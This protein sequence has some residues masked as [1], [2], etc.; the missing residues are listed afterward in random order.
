M[1]LYLGWIQGRGSPEWTRM[2]VKVMLRGMIINMCY[3]DIYLRNTDKFYLMNGW[4]T[5]KTSSVEP[6]SIERSW[7]SIVYFRTYTIN[8]SGVE[9]TCVKITQSSQRT[10][11]FSSYKDNTYTYSHTGFLHSIGSPH[12]F[13]KQNCSLLW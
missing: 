5:L 12:T 4:K 2:T 11:I 10:I 8:L 1:N 7:L 9:C 6:L 3:P 13:P